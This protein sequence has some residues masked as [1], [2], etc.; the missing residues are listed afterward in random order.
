MLTIL[1]S[2]GAIANE[3]TSLLAA[4]R[5]PF[6]QVSRKGA[7][8]KGAAETLA[9]DISNK[10]QAIGAVAGSSI[11]FL[12]VGLKYDHRV[13]EE[14]WPRIM[15]NTIEACKRAGA[16]LVFFDNV[17]MYGWVRGAMTEETPYRPTSR[18]GEVRARIATS[19][20]E[21]WMSGGLTAMIARSADFYGPNARTGIPNVLFFDP[22]SKRQ[23]ASCLI[24]EVLPHSYTYTPDAAK[25]LLALAETESAWNQVWHLPTAPAPLT[26]REFLLKAADVLGVKPKYRVLRRPM[27]RVA[28][29]FNPMVR[30]LYEMLYQND[31]PYIFDSSKYARAFGFAGTPYAEG[32]RATAAAYGKKSSG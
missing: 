30:E 26:G 3:L 6:R 18:K 24:S 23:T 25:A 19:L 7:G 2:G 29:W 16:K 14:T 22:L 32:I 15:A 9:A 12:L 10:E 28:G 20:Q 5:T 17:Y 1:G 13:W 21:A 11:V 27:L 31:S 4:R 8:V